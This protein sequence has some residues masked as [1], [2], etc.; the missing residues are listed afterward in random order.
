LRKY[1]PSCLEN[2]IKIILYVT[3]RLALIT[4]ITPTTQQP[5]YHLYE[6]EAQL[7]QR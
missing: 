7:P 1:L 2:V 5:L 4:I 6:Q 3:S